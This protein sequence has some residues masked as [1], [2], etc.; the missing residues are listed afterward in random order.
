[1]EI[2]YRPIREEVPAVREPGG[3]VRDH[4]E[5]IFQADIPRQSGP[6]NIAPAGTGVPPVDS[7]LLPAE[8]SVLGK[9]LKSGSSASGLTATVPQRDS[10]SLALWF[11]KSD[12][13]SA[14]KATA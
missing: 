9:R 2:S 3:F 6:L 11:W 1:M 8:R 4:Y 12:P 7:H 10:G 14:G 5:A 13:E